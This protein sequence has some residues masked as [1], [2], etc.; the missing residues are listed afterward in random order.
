[1]RYLCNIWRIAKR[2]M[3]ILVKNPIYLCCMLVFP[4]L[5]MLFFTT[6]LGEG[7]PQEMPVGVVD[8]DNTHRHTGRQSIVHQR[9]EEKHHQQR[10]EHHAEAVDV[11]PT[12]NQ[13][14]SQHDVI[15]LPQNNHV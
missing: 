14:L 4:L 10:K 1:M 8:L 13:Q 7:V 3:L 12:Q 6:L 2:E 5:T 11:I 15:Y 9:G